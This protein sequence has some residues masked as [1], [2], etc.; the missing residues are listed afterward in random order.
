MRNDFKRSNF[1]LY[2]LGQL[3]KFSGRAVKSDVSN[4]NS[5]ISKVKKDPSQDNI[6]ELK[7]FS[8]VVK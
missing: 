8:E 5:L 2:S 4:V 7:N 1:S 6:N 3:I